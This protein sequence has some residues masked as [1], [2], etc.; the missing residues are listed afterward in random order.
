L[1]VFFGGTIGNFQYDERIAFLRLIASTMKPGDRFLIG[2][3]MVKS[4]DILEAAYNDSKGITSEFNKN[5]LH[6]INR[7]L[8][9]NFNPAF[10]NHQAFY[11]KEKERVEM[12]LQANRRVKAEIC[13]LQLD[14]EF[15][16]GET[17]QTEICKKFRRDSAEQMFTKAGLAVK[18][19]FSDSHGW[20]SLAELVL[21]DAS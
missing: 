20:F 2:F 10:F 15:E 14:V 1:T 12:Y 8:N 4:Q 11:N 16:E 9:A 19:W 17:I 5:V 6:V 21:K 18:Q 7:E 13:D 3:D